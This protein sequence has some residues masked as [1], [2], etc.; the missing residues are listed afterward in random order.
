MVNLGARD[1]P[2]NPISIRDPNR[3]RKPLCNERKK[4]VRNLLRGTR[5]SGALHERFRTLFFRTILWNN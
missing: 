3:H 1:D 2:T 5:P 4:S